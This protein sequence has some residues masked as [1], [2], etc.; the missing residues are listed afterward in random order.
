M[1]VSHTA[2]SCHCTQVVV[3]VSFN[4]ICHMVTVS[5]CRVTMRSLTHLYSL[6]TCSTPSGPS[7]AVVAGLGDKKERDNIFQ[8]QTVVMYYATLEVFFTFAL[9]SLN[10]KFQYT[11]GRCQLL[12]GKFL[13]LFVWY[14][15]YL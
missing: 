2:L 12:F 10:N 4:K 15:F 7:T 5:S 9:F 6:F 1:P 14:I 8:K 13:I 11:L 3:L